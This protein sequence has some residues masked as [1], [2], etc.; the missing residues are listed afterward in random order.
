M[1]FCVGFSG[2][3]SRSLVG[4]GMGFL[5]IDLPCCVLHLQATILPQSQEDESGNLAS[6]VGEVDCCSCDPDVPADGIAGPNVLR[7]FKSKPQLAGILG[8]VFRTEY[9]IF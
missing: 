3:N 2:A 1:V 8:S 6:Y 4:E 9:A 7:P 5:V